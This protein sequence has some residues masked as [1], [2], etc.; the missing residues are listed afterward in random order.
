MPNEPEFG[1]LV[2]D[3]TQSRAKHLSA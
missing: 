1:A 3:L 2:L